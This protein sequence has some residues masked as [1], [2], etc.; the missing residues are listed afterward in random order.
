MIEQR[1]SLHAKRTEYGKQI[2]KEYEAHQITEKWANIK[3]LEP[4]N[5]NIC[6]TLTTAT[7]DNLYVGRVKMDFEGNKIETTQD[8][9]FEGNEEN[10]NGN[11]D[12]EQEE[13]ESEVEEGKT[14]EDYLYKDFG[15]F[16]LS[17]RECGR[18]MNVLDKDID[19]MQKVNSNTQM[20]RQFGNSIVVSVLAAIFSQ[21]HIQGKKA[22]NERTD[23][24]K[25]ELIYDKAIIH[26]E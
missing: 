15:I 7:K 8:N 3:A 22:W 11:E 17:A 21:L 14:I 12:G 25:G 20:Y 26:G 6:G 4:R 24:E 13:T 23:V 19:E 5:D 10:W 16:K 2:R 1:K 18:L 9:E